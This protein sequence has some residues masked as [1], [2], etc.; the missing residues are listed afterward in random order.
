MYW[1]GSFSVFGYKVTLKTNA[2]EKRSGIKVVMYSYNG[3]SNVKWPQNGWKRNDFGT[4]SMYEGDSRNPVPR[5]R[6]SQF[7]W[8]SAHEFGHI[9]GVADAYT[10]NAD[11]VSIF[12]EFG[13]N[14]QNIDIEK[15]LRAFIL[16]Q[17]QKW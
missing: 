14:V 9:L 4:I 8:V 15:V 3:T 12:N 13:T 6:Y 10:E 16:N 1:E 11:V 2:K 5:Y 17:L 7:T